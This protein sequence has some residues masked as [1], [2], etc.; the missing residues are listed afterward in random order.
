MFPLFM[1]V[2]GGGGGS[3]PFLVLGSQNLKQRQQGI[4]ILSE[5]NI[6]SHR[7]TVMTCYINGTKLTS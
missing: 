3:F 1:L 2:G 6:F 7:I 4:F 5:S